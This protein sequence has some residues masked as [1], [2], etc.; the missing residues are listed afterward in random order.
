MCGERRPTPE[1]RTDEPCCPHLILQGKKEVLLFQ[2][3]KKLMYSE[4]F[5][6]FS[7]NLN[8]EKR[9]L[10]SINPKMKHDNDSFLLQE[11]DDSC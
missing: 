7:E 1:R 2:S 9:S 4:Y 8:M 3:K 11:R 5:N 6:Y 10:C